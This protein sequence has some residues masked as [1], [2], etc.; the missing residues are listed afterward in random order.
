MVARVNDMLL[1][2]CNRRT[3]WSDGHHSLVPRRMMLGPVGC[4]LVNSRPPLQPIGSHNNWEM[5][6]MWSWDAWT[7]ESAVNWDLSSML[8][9]E[10][11]ARER[12]GKRW[13]GRLIIT[14]M[15]RRPFN[16]TK[17]KTITLILAEK[18]NKQETSGY[19]CV[20]V[21]SSKVNSRKKSPPMNKRM[22][23]FRNN[24]QR[25]DDLI[26]CFYYFLALTLTLCLC[27]TLFSDSLRH[28]ESFFVVK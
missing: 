15:T 5:Y 22:V 27:W 1:H 3:D 8:I 12:D 24:K 7:K 11:T 25:N 23:V 9:E 21:Y 20:C 6:S 26:D 17:A 13:Q 10:G 2:H 4:S 19:I 16:N 14:E 18:S 28:E